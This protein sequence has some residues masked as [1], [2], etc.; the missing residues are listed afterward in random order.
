MTRYLPTNDLLFRKIFTSP[1]SKHLLQHF[2]EDFLGQRFRTLIP[3]EHYHIKKYQKSFKK[4]K[5]QRTE[6]DILA[7]TADGLMTTIEMQTVLRSKNLDYWTS[8]RMKLF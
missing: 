2:I 8:K 7:T 1:A 6:V 4:G 3:K 5:L